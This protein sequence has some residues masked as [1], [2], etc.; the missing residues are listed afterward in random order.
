[1]SECHTLNTIKP[2]SLTFYISYLF[3][4]VKHYWT[5]KSNVS[6]KN[7]LSFEDQ[8]FLYSSAFIKADSLPS[9]ENCFCFVA[10][11]MFKSR[12]IWRHLHDVQNQ[13]AK[14]RHFRLRLGIIRYFVVRNH[15]ASKAADKRAKVCT[16]ML[17]FTVKEGK[18]LDHELV[19]SR[20]V[21]PQ[22]AENFLQELGTVSAVR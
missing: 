3:N 17:Y 9:D 13:V 6:V 8:N 20:A 16:G 12:K 11:I 19:A 15:S 14:T 7:L 4:T 21:S 18:G 10:T 1:M 5:D 22:L 2:F